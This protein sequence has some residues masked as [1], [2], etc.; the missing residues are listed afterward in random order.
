VTVGDKLTTV[1]PDSEPRVFDIEER[2]ILLVWDAL[3]TAIEGAMSDQ[4]I[5]KGLWSWQSFVQS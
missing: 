3:P 1:E 5:G 2:L 4:R